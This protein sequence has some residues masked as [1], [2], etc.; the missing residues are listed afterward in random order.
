MQ[1][2]DFQLA[3]GE[4]DDPFTRQM[5][6]QE[7]AMMHP[8][9]WGIYMLPIIEEHLDP[10][11]DPQNMTESQIR[12]YLPRLVQLLAAHHFCLTN[13]NHLDDRALYQHILAEVLPKPIGIGPNPVGGILYHECCPCDDLDRWLAYYATDDDR[14]FWKHDWDGP[15]PEKKPLVSDRDIW[16]E[17][18][19]E[20][21]RNDPLPDYGNDS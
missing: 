4:Q 7:N 15:L 9:E 5:I 13:S 2:K 16:L 3:Y 11:M 19:A 12:C 8:E 18:L 10:P 20:S 14:E 6:E 1:N 21:F 17:I